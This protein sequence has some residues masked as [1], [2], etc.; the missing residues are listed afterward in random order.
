MLLKGF[1]TKLNPNN[2]QRTK[3]ARHAGCARWAYNWGLD[4]QFKAL[5]ARNEAKAD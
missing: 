3:F 5:A 4:Q 1:K 2:H